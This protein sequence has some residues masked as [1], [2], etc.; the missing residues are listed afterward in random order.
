MEVRYWDAS[1]F[2]AHLNK[3]EER[4]DTCEA[5]LELARRGEVLIATSAVT[6]TEVVKL[7]GKR[8]IGRDRASKIR[9]FFKHEWISVR[10]ADR[11][12]AEMA[13]DLLWDYP[14]LDYKDAI[15][16]AT[17]IRWQIG[18][19]ETYDEDHLLPLNG[20]IGQPALVIRLPHAK[21]PVLPLREGETQE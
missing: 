1:A 18:C 21:Q 19:L 9:E 17:A 13:Q 15:H 11:K 8:P 3:E 10:D 6:L 2:I 16:V 20:R 4:V 14:A 7:E 12:V 5:I